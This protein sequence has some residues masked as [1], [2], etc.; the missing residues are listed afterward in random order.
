MLAY[1]DP[2]AVCVACYLLVRVF[3]GRWFLTDYNSIKQL[4]S[5]NEN[6]CMQS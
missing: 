3:L 6:V 4:S 5:I 2:L 1:R